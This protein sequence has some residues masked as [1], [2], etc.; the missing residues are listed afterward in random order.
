MCKKDLENFL[1]FIFNDIWQRGQVCTRNV[2]I[3]GKSKSLEENFL[4]ENTR[5]V[6]K[7]AHGENEEV[8]ES[9]L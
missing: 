6:N 5:Q 3:D 7:I 4:K 8:A 9:I 2:A 1:V